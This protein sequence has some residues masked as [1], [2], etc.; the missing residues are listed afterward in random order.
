MSPSDQVLLFGCL[1]R[2]LLLYVVL[3][4][5]AGEMDHRII[6]GDRFLVCP[7]C[8]PELDDVKSFEVHT[9]TDEG[10]KLHSLTELGGRTT[11]D[12]FQAKVVPSVTDVGDGIHGDVSHRKLHSIT[13][14]GGRADDDSFQAKVV[15]SVTDVGDGGHGEVSQRKLHSIT[16][17]GGRAA[18]DGFQAKVVPSVTDVSDGVH[19][20][21]SHRKLHSVAKVANEVR[22]ITEVGGGV[23][24]NVH[25]RKLCSIT[26][27]ADEV[28]YIT[29]SATEVPVI[30]E[31]GGSVNDDV[32]H[33]VRPVTEVNGG[34][35][36]DV[37]VRFVIEV[38][39]YAAAD[40][41]HVI[42]NEGVGADGKLSAS[43]V[44]YA[45]RAEANTAAAGKWHR[46]PTDESSEHNSDCLIFAMM[47]MVVMAVGRASERKGADG[48]HAPHRR[49]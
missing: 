16:E 21:V 49:F 41:V 46:V 47:V 4:A 3:S 11:A 45:A 18:T 23:D 15:L 12:G 38:D 20:D 35:D 29:W 2:I 42:T 22:D 17:L 19:G 31:V 30:T 39:G 37:N 27:V 40:K 33:Q 34:V 43:Q 28:L 24:G 9:I 7:G 44:L 13:E 5:M 14:L 8:V 1:R 32:S 26:E 6:N 25:H 10:G 48:R 36:G